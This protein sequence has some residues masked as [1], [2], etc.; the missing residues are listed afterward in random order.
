MAA[1]VYIQP[2][3]NTRESLGE[4][5][6]LCDLILLHKYFQIR[7]GNTVTNQSQRA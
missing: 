2:E 5:E 7:L 6:S 3:A 1:R 4:F